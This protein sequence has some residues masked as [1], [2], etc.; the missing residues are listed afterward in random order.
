MLLYQWAGS[1]S[2]LFR[3]AGQVKG[4]MGQLS[5]ALAR[6]AQAFGAEI[7]SGV[8]LSHIIVTGGR[9]AG[10]QLGGGETI[11]ADCII[12]AV[13]P[14][15]TFMKL[16]GPRLLPTRFLQHLSHIKYRGSTAR[17]HLALEALPAFNGIDDSELLRGAIQIGPN[18]NYLQRAYDPVKYGRFS[19]RP[20][21][22]FRIPS[23]NDPSLAPNGQHT[24][25]ITIKYAPY[26]L[27][28]SSWTA[29][30][31]RLEAVALDT[32]AA[33]SP[34]IKDL[35]RHNRLLTPADLESG[36]N[37]PEGSL[38]HGEMTLD[39]FFH[40]RPVPGW[41]NYAAPIANLYLC[42]PGTHPGGGI[43][44]LPGRN[45][46]REIGNRSP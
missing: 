5:Q 31:A 28:N 46:A 39:Q 40:M 45:A 37:L 17:L 8:E 4:G 9:A 30:G 36:Y 6:S 10:V 21:L 19:E 42:G 1:N 13:D 12:S 43:T 27:R 32:L 7:R 20:Y 2:G 29:E 44:G 3:S 22:D 14:Q 26:Q 25:S 11:Q 33:Y 15:T 18:M 41:A 34:N 24:M 23:L 38:Y 16:V 35:I